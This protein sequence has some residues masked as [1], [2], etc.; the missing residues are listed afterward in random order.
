MHSHLKKV[1]F[2]ESTILGRLDEMAEAI[3]R[4]YEGRELQVILI[5]HGSLFFAADL[6]RR[7][8][9]RL[10]LACLDVSSYH[11]ET[12][13]SGVVTVGDFHLPGAGGRDLLVVD[14]I[15][16]TGRTL[17]AICDRIQAECSPASLRVCVLL[18]KRRP[19]V[20]PAVADYVGFKIDD[21][22]VVGYGL[23]YRGAYRNLPFIGIL[24]DELIREKA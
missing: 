5:L 11:G 14:D 21:E 12:T 18:E 16:D 7:V 24:D 10:R 20:A 4:D 17:A 23:D 3:T 13:S 1:L 2:E 9:L 6:L 19:R 8:N 22:F 15:L